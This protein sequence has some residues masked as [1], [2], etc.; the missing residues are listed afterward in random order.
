ME[1]VIKTE[2]IDR[3]KFLY[4]NI[5][6]IMMPIVY[7][8]SFGK[9]N[10]RINKRFLDSLEI[11]LLSDVPYNLTNF[12]MEILNAALDTSFVNTC[13]EKRAYLDSFFG[14]KIIDRYD[15]KSL[16]Q[17]ARNFILGQAD[18]LAR[19]KK[20]LALDEYF[21]VNRYSNS[22]FIIKGGAVLGYEDIGVY[23]ERLANRD[24]PYKFKR[25]Y[26]LGGNFLDY[27]ADPDN[28]REENNSI[29]SE[30][31]KQ[32]LYLELHPGEVSWNGRER[33]K[34]S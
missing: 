25:S 5:D 22:S 15:T 10:I 29:F 13:K 28:H 27:L 12:Y 6:L 23:C 14:K 3:Y 2:F 8:E 24:R 34:S 26:L 21:R 18:S 30:D 31:E 17:I 33:K 32:D 1:E 4:N 19:D 11:F 20:L 16:L 7:E 9:F